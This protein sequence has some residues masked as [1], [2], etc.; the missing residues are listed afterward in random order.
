MGVLSPSGRSRL[1]PS[2]GSKLIRALFPIRLYNRQLNRFS[3]PSSG[4]L[5]HDDGGELTSRGTLRWSRCS[6]EQAC[7]DSQPSAAGQV[8][9]SDVSDP[10]V[11]RNPR[12]FLRP[13][14]MPQPRHSWRPD[15]RWR[16]A[17]PGQLA[18]ARALP[19]GKPDDHMHSHAGLTSDWYGP[20]APL[21]WSM[22]EAALKVI[23]LAF[24][25]RRPLQSDPG[26][27]IVI[28]REPSPGNSVIIAA[29][30]SSRPGCSSRSKRWPSTSA[31]ELAA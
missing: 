6:R 4:V 18:D 31:A 12:C 9:D 10:S 5:D 13:A 3:P 27:R 16:N 11:G 20:I 14:S 28:T 25:Q 8:A 7:R 23:A 1:S 26:R 15:P 17:D 21:A 22:R 24:K 2:D 30:C 29:G 19:A